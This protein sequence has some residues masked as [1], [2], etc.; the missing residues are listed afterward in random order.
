MNLVTGW[1]S[2]IERVEWKELDCNAILKHSTFIPIGRVLSVGVLAH[3]FS[4]KDTIPPWKGLLIRNGAVLD[5]WQKQSIPD[6][7]G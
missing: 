3:M 2:Q 6:W 4:T 7:V 1:F 5:I